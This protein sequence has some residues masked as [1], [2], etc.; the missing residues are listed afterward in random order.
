MVWVGGLELRGHILIW[1][2][3]EAWGSTR[4]LT[5]NTHSRNLQEG[6]N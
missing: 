3:E 4:K 5:H 6:L 1:F 2:Q